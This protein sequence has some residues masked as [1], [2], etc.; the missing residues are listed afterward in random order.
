L[1][2]PSIPHQSTFNSPPEGHNSKFYVI[3]VGQQ[4]GL[5]FHWN[6]VAQRVNRVSGNIHYKCDMF[7]EALVQYTRA[8]KNGELCAIPMPGSPFWPTKS[9]T[10]SSDEEDIWSHIED[11]SEQMS[12]AHI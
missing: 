11:L 2:G 10:M 6:D 8:Y 12:N 3:T 5:F 1:Y 9:Q 4:V 7:Q